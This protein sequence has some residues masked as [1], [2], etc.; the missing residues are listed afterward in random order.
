MRTVSVPNE[1]LIPQVKEFIDAGHTATFRVRGN[2]M[3]LFLKDGR[4]KVVLAP[5]AEVKVRDVVLAEVSPR[6]YVLHRVIKK[7]GE[8]LVLKGDGNV[9]GTESC[10]THDVIGKAVGF[11]RK[12]RARTDRVDAWKWRAYSR[13]WLMLAPFRRYIL[14]ACRHLGL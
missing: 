14:W 4:D 11:I 6:R 10:S 8:R 1:I 12:G 5:C 3:R 9:Y 7:N 13:L 2:S